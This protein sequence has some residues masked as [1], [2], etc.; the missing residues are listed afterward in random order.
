MKTHYKDI[1][2]RIP[3][4]PKWYE[5]SGVPRYDDFDVNLISSI[6]LSEVCYFLIS[7]AVCFREFRVIRST[8][9]IGIVHDGHTLSDQIPDIFYGVPPNISCCRNGPCTESV[10]LRVLEFWER[11]YLDIWFR[12]PD[13]EV[14]LTQIK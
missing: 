13:L 11:G 2:S 8:E 12:R 1:L 7:C 4:E 9:V 10:S 5:E 14:P 3:E 6:Y